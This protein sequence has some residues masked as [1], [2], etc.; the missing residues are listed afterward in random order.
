MVHIF[1]EENRDFY[2]LE[3]LWKDAPKVDVDTL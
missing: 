3:T 2:K 1:N